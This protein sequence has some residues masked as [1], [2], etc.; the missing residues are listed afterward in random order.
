MPPTPPYFQLPMTPALRP[1]SAT[2]NS[3]TNDTTPS[4]ST[5]SAPADQRPVPQPSRKPLLRLHLN[6]L[7]HPGASSF[8]SLLPL[9]HCLDECLAG[10]LRL[11]YSAPSTSSTSPPTPA[12]PTIP[13]TRSV[14]LVLRAMPG[15]A[16]TRSLDLDADHKEI[17]LSTSYIT[18]TAPPRRQ[19]EIL[20]VLR[21]EMV[22]CFQHNG[23]GTAPG[24]LIE[25]V[26]D[27]VRLRSGFVPPHWKRE[28]DGE[29]D[30]GYQ[31][32]GYFLEYLEG[33]FGEG[34]VG[35][36]NA[37]L[38]EG[39]YEEEAFWVGLFGCR[40]GVLWEEYG[41]WLKEQGGGEKE[42]G[43]KKGEEKKG[44][45]KSEKQEEE[46]VRKEEETDESRW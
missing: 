40:V 3:T 35:R 22:H 23:S 5:P 44:E 33:R 1:V 28:A 7:S 38:G 9:P 45:E 2:A 43:E 16:Y 8:L 41:Q 27:W 4:N 21:H 17:H 20:G 6:D 42:G 24:G 46:G 31:H 36:I 29:W 30:A 14:T 26:A 25:G 15:V 34:S 32:T 39:K 10:V 13:P 37:R 12:S 11:L 19:A 18:S